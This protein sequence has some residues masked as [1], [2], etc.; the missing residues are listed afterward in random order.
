MKAIYLNIKYFFKN[1]YFVTFSG[2]VTSKAF[3]GYGRFYLAKKYADKRTASGS[4]DG[5]TGRKRH[6]VISYDTNI[7]MV[8]NRTEIN[9]MAKTGVIMKQNVAKL[10]RDAYYVS[11]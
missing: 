11:K 10:L 6:Y 9:N 2:K 4:P 7:I 5:V 8:C 1:W 3:A